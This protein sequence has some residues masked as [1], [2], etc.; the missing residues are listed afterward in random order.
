MLL[1]KRLSKSADHSLLVGREV[2]W[3]EGGDAINC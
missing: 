3:N 2:T 1:R